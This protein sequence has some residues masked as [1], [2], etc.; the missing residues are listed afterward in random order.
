MTQAQL[1]PEQPGWPYS[2]SPFEGLK[3]R[4]PAIPLAA[5]VLLLGSVAFALAAA[6]LAS[7]S[8][9]SLVLPIIVLGVVTGLALAAITTYRQGGTR[10]GPSNSS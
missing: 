1:P 5:R 7:H 6:I 9:E 2:R 10:A 4:L 8:D 3:P